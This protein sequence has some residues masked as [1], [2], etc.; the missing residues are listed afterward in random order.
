MIHQNMEL[1]CRG[2]RHRKTLKP[3]RQ[4]IINMWLKG[5]SARVISQTTGVSV[6]TVHRWVRRWRDEGTLEMSPYLFNRQWNIPL[7]YTCKRWNPREYKLHKQF[8]SFP[9]LFSQNV[10]N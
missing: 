7:F 9:L 1:D 4:L 8:N 5:S 3:E 6:S 10:M 2:Y